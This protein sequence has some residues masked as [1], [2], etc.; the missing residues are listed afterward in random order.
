[1]DTFTR[2]R[3]HKIAVGPLTGTRAYASTRA[4]ESS[5][6]HTLHAQ[7]HAHA[8]THPH[9]QTHSRAFRVCALEE[10]ANALCA[11][12]ARFFRV[13]GVENLA[14]MKKADG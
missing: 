14:S 9:A 8:Q 7:A 1:M 4:H 13:L 3:V 12:R 6:A 11:A 10:V 5:H 2:I